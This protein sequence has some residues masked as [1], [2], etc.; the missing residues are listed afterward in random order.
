MSNLPVHNS[1]L[2]EPAAVH[3]IGIQ[4]ARC[5]ALYKIWE[6]SDD[7]YMEW[8]KFESAIESFWYGM[9]ALAKL[10]IASTGASHFNL[11]L[12]NEHHRVNTYIKECTGYSP[13]GNEPKDHRLAIT[14]N[15]Y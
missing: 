9:A 3:F 11:S 12:S 10:S 7:D 15:D 13:I 1:E 2:Y 5:E 8:L 4:Y 14:M 6:N